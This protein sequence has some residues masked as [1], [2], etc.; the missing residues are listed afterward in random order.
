[1]LK[2]ISIVILAL[3]LGLFSY[4]TFA[5]A[6]LID[7]LNLWNGFVDKLVSP[8]LFF[9]Q[10]TNPTEIVAILSTYCGIFVL[11]QVGISII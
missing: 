5:V 9:R 6:M 7:V 3:V 8:S 11:L 2:K 4:Q 1:M 10:N